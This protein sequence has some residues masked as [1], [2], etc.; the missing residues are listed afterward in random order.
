MAKH[1]ATAHRDEIRDAM[2]RFFAGREPALIMAA[3]GILIKIVC[4]FGLNLSVDQQSL[5]NA[6]VATVVGMLVAMATRDGLSAAVLGIVQAI[7][8]LAIGF[9]LG[10]D[11]ENQALIM[12]LVATGVG[13]FTRTQVIAPVPPPQ[14]PH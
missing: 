5:I 4:A 13:M 7:I 10:I 9:G 6:L 12:S 3:A 14:A 8:A 2:N 1:R 11:A